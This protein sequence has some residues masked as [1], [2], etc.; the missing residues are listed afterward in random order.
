MKTKIDNFWETKQLTELTYE[1]WEALCDGCGL[2]C[3]HR[4]VCD[5]DSIVSTNVVCKCFDIKHGGCKDYPNRFKIVPECMQL[6]LQRVKEFDWLPETCAYRLRHAGK[7]L[8]SWHPLISGTKESVRIYGVNATN[9][10]EET[11]DII[12]ED[13]IVD[14]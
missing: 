14:W 8:P 12:L 7:P 5:D 2:C 13:H 6:T 4:L 3:V 11:D 9:H 10:I 1:E